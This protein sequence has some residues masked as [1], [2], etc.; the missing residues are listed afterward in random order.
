MMA[1]KDKLETRITDC[2]DRLSQ[3][4]KMI[5]SLGGERARWAQRSKELAEQYACLVGDMTVAS[6]MCT[7]LGPF[8]RRFRSEATAEWLRTLRSR[9][10]RCSSARSFS[11]AS[12]LGDP[13][14]VRR[15]K[16]HGL[17]SDVFSV[18]SA[19]MMARS[20]K[21]PLFIDPQTTASRW[22]RDCT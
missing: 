1:E 14:T 20:A 15:W 5:G 12:V 10:V 17:P 7:Y 4:T 11:L 6:A 19:V 22:V 8:D 2:A 9:G 3:A 13:A 21:P 16:L 18:S